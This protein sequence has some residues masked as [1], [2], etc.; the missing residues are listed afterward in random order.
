VNDKFVCKF[1]Y[2]SQPDGTVSKTEARGP[3]G[4]LWAEYRGRAVQELARD[5]HDPASAVATIYRR[6]NWW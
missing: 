3:D 6:G 4:K 1:V 5:G 2:D